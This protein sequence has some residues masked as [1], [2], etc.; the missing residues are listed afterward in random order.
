MPLVIPSLAELAGA[1]AIPAPLILL[2]PAGACTNTYAAGQ[3]NL[4]LIRWGTVNKVVLL[5]LVTP[6]DA[7]TAICLVIAIVHTVHMGQSR[8]HQVEQ[9]VLGVC[10]CLCKSVSGVLQGCLPCLWIVIDPEPGAHAGKRTA[11]NGKTPAAYDWFKT[12]YSQKCLVAI[13]AQQAGKSPGQK[14]DP[15]LQGRVPVRALYGKSMLIYL[16]EVMDGLQTEHHHTLLV[17]KTSQVSMHTHIDSDAPVCS[18]LCHLRQSAQFTQCVAADMHAADLHVHIRQGLRQGL[19]EGRCIRLAEPNSFVLSRLC[20]A[21]S[22]LKSRPQ[23][24]ALAHLFLLVISAS[25]VRQ[26][27]LA[28]P[29]IYCKGQVSWCLKC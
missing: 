27:Y 22:L 29:V 8:Q 4:K 14:L 2:P 1:A 13:S 11:G 10:L 26:I 20:A 25:P 23:T 6:T 17:L 19:G 24:E 7:V 18:S 5:T 9:V 21:S 28:S 15:L 16:V 12:S 3:I